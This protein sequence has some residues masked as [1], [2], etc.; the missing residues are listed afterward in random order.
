MMQIDCFILQIRCLNTVLN[1]LVVLY[2]ESVI[3]T[4]FQT[5]WTFYTVNILF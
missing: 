4:L 2:C 3:L 5:T 1:Y